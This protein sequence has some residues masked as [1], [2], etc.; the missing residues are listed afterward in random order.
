MVSLGAPRFPRDM[1]ANRSG[2]GPGDEL[3]KA[4]KMCTLQRL[5]MSTLSLIDEGSSFDSMR[6][7]LTTCLLLESSRAKTPKNAT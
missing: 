3:K 4:A 6:A 2:H 7:E 5:A 1:R